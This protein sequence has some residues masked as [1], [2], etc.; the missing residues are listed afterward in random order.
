MHLTPYYSVLPSTTLR[1]R[2]HPEHQAWLKD[3]HAVAV[4]G[5]NHTS[6]RFPVVTS[7]YRHAFTVAGEAPEYNCTQKVLVAP[8]FDIASHNFSKRRLTKD[9]ERPLALLSPRG[10]PASPQALKCFYAP[11]LAAPPVPQTPAPLN[12]LDTTPS[13]HPHT[14]YPLVLSTCQASHP[15]TPRPPFA[16]TPPTPHTRGPPPPAPFRRPFKPACLSQRQREAC[17]AV[18]HPATRC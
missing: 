13:H 7:G 15:P 14:S 6:C 11:K 4:E 2:A 12:T 5:E 9:T 1:G 16:L 8:S 17:T 3:R 10:T 18:Q